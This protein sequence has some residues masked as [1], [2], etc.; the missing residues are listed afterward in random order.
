MTLLRHHS[1]YLLFVI[2]AVLIWAQYFTTVH[3]QRHQHV[4]DD[5]VVCKIAQTG[6]DKAQ[7][8]NFQYSD[9]LKSEFV[10]YSYLEIPLTKSI[11]KTSLSRAPPVS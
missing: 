9:Y 1:K 4:N 11:W 7:V 8:E 3:D 5:C 10:S 6:S 2:S